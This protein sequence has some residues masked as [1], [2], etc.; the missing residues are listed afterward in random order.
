LGDIR[1]LKVVAS[2]GSV[3]ARTGYSAELWQWHTSIVAKILDWHD[4]LGVT[5]E[6]HA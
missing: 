3:A 2:I 5:D 4:R 1:L 6:L